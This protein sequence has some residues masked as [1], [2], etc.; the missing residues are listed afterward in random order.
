MPILFFNFISRAGSV[1]HQSFS[2]F[3]SLKFISIHIT[4]NTISM[5]SRVQRKQ[6]KQCVF[7]YMPQ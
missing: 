5:G 6:L 3:L 1:I 7:Y 2:L 4:L